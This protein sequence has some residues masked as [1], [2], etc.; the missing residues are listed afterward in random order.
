MSAQ[1]T[2]GPKAVEVVL[3]LTPSE[4]NFLKREMEYGA[5]AADDNKEFKRVL[6]KVK[7]AIANW[8]IRK[9]GGAS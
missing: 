5:D 4:A 1:H 9:A 7:R 3:R 2:P 6:A 8:Q